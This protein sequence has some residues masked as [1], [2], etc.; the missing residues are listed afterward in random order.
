M[1]HPYRIRALTTAALA[2]AFA[3]NAAGQQA[4]ERQVQPGA[5]AQSIMKTTAPGDLVA[6]VVKNELTTHGGGQYRYRDWEKTPEGSKT[7]EVIETIDGNVSRLIAL[8][9]QALTPE[10]RAQ[11]EARL[12]SLP[13]HPELQR[14][15]LRDQEQDAKKVERMFRELP[16]AFVYEYEAL[17]SGETGDIVKL[18]FSPNPSYAPSSHEMAVFKGMSGRMWLNVTHFRLARIEGTL[19]REV[20]FGWGILAHLNKGGHFN[21]EQTQIGPERWEA[22]ST[23]IQFSG[24]ALF[25]KTIN[26]HEVEKLSD[27]RQV[28]H[29]LTLAQG[30]A[31]LEKGQD[32]LAINAD[33]K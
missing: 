24:K 26:L 19:F 22:T 11:E 9:D 13:Q 7:Q 18:K 15:H 23:N 8:N 12:Q 1:H 4:G 25:F 2:L 29:S 5:D 10:Q 27:F 21:V 3:L 28:P 17:E 30:V 33:H 31:I 16:R 14:R 20:T 32:E 6:R